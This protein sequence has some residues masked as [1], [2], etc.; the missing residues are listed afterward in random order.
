VDFTFGPSVWTNGTICVVASNVGENYTSCSAVEEV[1]GPATPT[2]IQIS[3]GNATLYL[4]GSASFYVD[5]YNVTGGS[6]EGA[7]VTWALSPPSLGF[8]YPV[9]KYTVLF[10]VGSAVG[11]GSL[12]A[13]ATSG[14]GGVGACA[15]VSVEARAP[16]GSSPPPGLVHHPG[17]RTPWWVYGIVSVAAA[18]ALVVTVWGIQRRRS[19]QVP[20]KAP[21]NAPPE[22]GLR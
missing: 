11:S 17:P 5:V 22:V 15:P 18:T 19:K 1:P 4:N 16:Q 21:V 13:T 20:P 12:C 6:L 3:P 2:A 10:E 9:A 7:F 14:I 8:L